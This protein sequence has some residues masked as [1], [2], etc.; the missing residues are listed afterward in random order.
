MRRQFGIKNG[1]YMAYLFMIGLFIGILLVNLGHETW[2]RNG[3]LLG[4]EMM[5]RLKSSRPAG[6]GLV[7]I[8]SGTGSLRAVFCV[9]FPRL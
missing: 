4:A 1:Y 2:I 5:N 8:F 6:E 9:W 3:S 7:D